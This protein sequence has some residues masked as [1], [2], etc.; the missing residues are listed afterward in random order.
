M[1]EQKPG[2]ITRF[3][4][5]INEYWRVLRI[6]K[7]PTMLEYKTIMKISGLGIA[8]IGLLGFIIQMTVEVIKRKGV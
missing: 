7:K 6:T 1:E 4:Y 8:V 3:K 5:K 2:L